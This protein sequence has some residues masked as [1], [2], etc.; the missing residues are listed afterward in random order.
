MPHSTNIPIYF[1]NCIVFWLEK[2]ITMAFSYLIMRLRESRSGSAEFGNANATLMETETI[3]L[4]LDV[5]SIIGF[6]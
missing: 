4:N 2:S 5:Y 3:R 6:D 1:W